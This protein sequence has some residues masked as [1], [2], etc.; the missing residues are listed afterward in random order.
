MR[1]SDNTRR[2]RREGGTVK[3]LAAQLKFTVQGVSFTVQ[4]VSENSSS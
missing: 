1:I 2:L 3:A 4:V